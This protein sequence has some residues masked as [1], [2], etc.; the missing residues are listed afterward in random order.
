MPLPHNRTS[1]QEFLC[2]RF[3][4]SEN[5]QGR[6]VCF[7]PMV[8]NRL[9]T[10]VVLISLAALIA[11]Q[12]QA[13]GLE[14]A[15]QAALTHDPQFRAAQAQALSSAEAIPQSVARLRPNVSLSAS[16]SEVQ[17]DRT[18]GSNRFPTQDY[19][20][21]NVTLSARQPLLNLRLA[22]GR[23]EALAL[24]ENAQ[25]A[26]EQERQTLATR[27]TAA[28]VAL[29]LGHEQE[30]LLQTQIR[31]AKTRLRAATKAFQAGTGIRTDID[32]IQA[33]SDLLDAQLLRARQSILS[34]RSELEQLTG[35]T[36]RNSIVLNA[37]AIRLEAIDP[38][39]LNDWTKE[40][41]DKNPEVIALRAQAQAALARLRASRADHFPVVDLVAQVSKNSSEN[42]FFVNSKT[43]SQVVGV[44]LNLPIYQGGGLQ[45]QERKALA[46]EQAA[47][48][49]AQ[50]ALNT[51]T[52]EAGRSFYVLREGI[53]RVRALDKAAIS[54]EQV[55]FANQRSFE[56]GLRSMLDI[57][58]AEQRLAQTQLELSEARL[59]LV[60]AWV[61]LQS[62]IAAADA[63]QLRIVAAWF[64]HD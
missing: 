9:S 56:A 2:C 4:V 51:A 48:E 29:V 46:D 40:I 28:Y 12:V 22:A 63:D 61:R 26:L 55:V 24:V 19:P 14:Q 54:A 50:R 8:R 21:Y 31:S 15:Y 20:T 33:Q 7:S 17:Q 41:A 6:Y 62:L 53:A 47:Q 27:V 18:D 57:L 10:A 60:S 5:L 30:R 45:S 64:R 3:P 1:Q 44:Q 11:P 25:A 52:L 36:V 43:N 42:S 32:E 35:H 39:S 13:I 49:L 58:A 23:N 16:R 34:A 38:G 59:Q 37:E